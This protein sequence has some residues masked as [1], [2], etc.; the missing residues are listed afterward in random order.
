M[1]VG[2]DYGFIFLGEHGAA[3][4]RRTVLEKPSGEGE[5]PVAEAIVQPGNEREYRRTR[6]IRWEAGMTTS[7]G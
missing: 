4:V 5:R 3:W 1:G 2:R 7:Q 6:E